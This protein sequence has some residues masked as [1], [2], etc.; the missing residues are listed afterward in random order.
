MIRQEL[1]TRVRTTLEHGDTGFRALGRMIDQ[2]NANTWGH[3][4]RVRQY[5]VTLAR[6]VELEA[7]AAQH[8]STTW[9]RSSSPSRSWTSPG[10]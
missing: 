4:E 9:A 3:S 5:A 7:S 10:R 2:A 1:E 8:W 6:A